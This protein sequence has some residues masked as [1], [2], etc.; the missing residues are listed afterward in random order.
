MRKRNLFQNLGISFLAVLM[1]VSSVAAAA[2]TATE[3]LTEASTELMTENTIL[4]AGT[5][6]ETEKDAGSEDATEM[7]KAE[8]EI[9]SEEKDQENTEPATEFISEEDTVASQ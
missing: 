4:T 1:A 2:E 8:T 5:E 7:Q 6:L 3:M 9:C